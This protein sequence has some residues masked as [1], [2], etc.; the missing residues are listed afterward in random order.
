M[1]SIHDIATESGLTVEQVKQCNPEL[2]HFIQFIADRL[3]QAEH[4]LSDTRAFYTRV[5]DTLED[6]LRPGQPHDTRH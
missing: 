5:I 4:E 3:A 6:S 2:I 1:I